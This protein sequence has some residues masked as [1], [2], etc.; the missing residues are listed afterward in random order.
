MAP[1]TNRRMHM[2]HYIGLLRYTA[3]GIAKVKESPARLDAARKVAASMGGK[4]TSW[5]LTMG[6]YDAVI[7]TEFPNDDACARFTLAVGA[8]G[9]VTT[10]TLKAFNED[11]HR[12]IVA[13]LP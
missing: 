5:H 12:K 2:P 9:N 7:L 4:I 1:S 13:S 3:Q 6:H 8:L 11:E 10:E